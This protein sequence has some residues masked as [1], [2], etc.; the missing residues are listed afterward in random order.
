MTKHVKELRQELIDCGKAPI[1]EFQVT[2]AAGKADFVSCEVSF[3]RN[4][5]RA[6]RDAVSTEEETSS[7]IASTS[8]AVEPGSTLD[9]NLQDLHERISSEIIEGGLYSL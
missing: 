2:D 4:S 3:V 1:F 5:I 8:M 7:K 6:S 9:E